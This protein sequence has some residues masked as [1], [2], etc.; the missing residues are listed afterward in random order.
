MGMGVFQSGLFAEMPLVKTMSFTKEKLAVLLRGMKEEQYKKGAILLSQGQ[1]ENRIRFVQKGVIRQFYVHRQKEFNT[2]F[3]SKN[4]IVC[5][6][7]SYMTE[8][9][10]DY[11]IEALEN[12]VLYSIDRVEM[13]KALV[14][15]GLRLIEFGRKIF[16]TLF[17][18]KTIRERELINDD[19]LMRLQNF[20]FAKPLLF[21]ALPQKHI[22]SYLN[23][24][25]ETFS[26]LKKKLKYP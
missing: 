7:A 1:E 10:S 12:S 25:P 13:N 6:L 9:P 21:M 8:A 14:D 24:T 16:S 17:I 19:A 18:E 5:S 22:A 23:I 11:I 3:A 15:G 20:L 26:N 2:Q 4:D